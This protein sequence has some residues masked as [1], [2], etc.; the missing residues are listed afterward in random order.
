VGADFPR[1]LG[2]ELLATFAHDKS[3]RVLAKAADAAC[4]RRFRALV[5]LLEAIAAAPENRAI[6]DSLTFS[7]HLLRDGVH[8][9][10]D[11]TR[12]RRCSDGSI[13]SVD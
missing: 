7:L 12:W 5:P 2:L 8:V 10:E 9:D 1:K 4:R 11:G 13:E 6:S 3:S